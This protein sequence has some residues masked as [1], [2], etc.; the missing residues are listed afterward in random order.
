MLRSS[1]SELTIPSPVAS[2][3]PSSDSSSDPNSKTHAFFASTFDTP[4]PPPTLAKSGSAQSLTAP[5]G[6]LLL[7]DRCNREKYRA[8]HGHFFIF[9]HWK[10][11]EEDEI[12]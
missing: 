1:W 6:T 7:V 5:D 12:S 2:P 10:N 3:P 9:F 4:L 11:R 8:E